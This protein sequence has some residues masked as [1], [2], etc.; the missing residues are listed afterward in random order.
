MGA[1]E[2]IHN[3]NDHDDVSD[4]LS[5]P[6]QPPA[7]AVQRGSTAAEAGAGVDEAASTEPSGAAGGPRKDTCTVASYAV[8]GEGD[9]P[10]RAGVASAGVAVL[11]RGMALAAVR[12][13][14]AGGA[15]EEPLWEAELPSEVGAETCPLALQP[16][17]GQVA[18]CMAKLKA[19]SQRDMKTGEEIKLLT[20][21][22]DGRFVGVNYSADGSLVLVFGRWG[23]KVYAA[24]T[25]E[26][27]RSLVDRAGSLVNNCVTTRPA[28][29]SS[30]PAGLASR[31]SRTARAA[32]TCTRWMPR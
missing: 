13:C 6:E 28:G 10:L 7:Q 18:V 2:D 15:D 14:G 29:S 5:P 26:L 23:T 9:K 27:L 3:E 22:L 16:T 8:P 21:G 25:G 32:R 12:R 1:D 20:G 11:A 19:V 31:S 4:Q 17:G 24:S 30:P